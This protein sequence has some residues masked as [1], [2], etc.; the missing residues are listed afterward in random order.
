MRGHISGVQALFRKEVPY[1]YYIHCNN[2]RLNLV[3][4]DVAK[5]VEEADKFFLLLQDIYVFMSGS[6]IHSKFMELQKKVG[7]CKPIELKRLCMTRW[8]SQIHSCR[9]LKSVLD[10]VLL[11]LNNIVL[12]KPDRSLEA[13]GLLNMID[14]QFIYLCNDLL[15]EIHIVIKYLQDEAHHN[16]YKEVEKKAISLSIKLPSDQQQQNRAKKVPKYLEKCVCTVQNLEKQSNTSEDDYK[17]NIYNL[18]LDRMISEI[19]KRFMHNEKFLSSITALHPQSPH[20]LKYDDI[21]PL[22]IPYS[23]DC[24]CERTFSCMKRVEK[25]YLRNSMNHDLMSSLS[26]IS[27]EKDEGKQLNIDEVIDTFSNAPKNRK[28]TL[29]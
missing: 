25:N 1:T 3:L 5:N 11:L 22:A 8:S 20:F 9:A 24:T 28:I 26:I 13:V 2:H 18:I 7:K 19:D 10:I 12:E 29:K 6:T 17:V 15:S 4:V 14:F 16:L 23:S 21:E 27:I